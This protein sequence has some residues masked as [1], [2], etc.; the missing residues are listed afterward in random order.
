MFL[1]IV[2]H[3]FLADKILRDEISLQLRENKM[4][5]IFVRFI[6]A[7]RRYKKGRREG[8]GGGHMR[9][10]GGREGKRKGGGWVI[11]GGWGYRQSKAELNVATECVECEWYVQYLLWMALYLLSLPHTYAG[12]EYTQ[13]THILL[14]LS[15]H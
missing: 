15:E 5:L 9:R 3:S 11:W 4:K 14:T 10:L 6:G 12:I 2:I 7:G 8:G 1:N 13:C